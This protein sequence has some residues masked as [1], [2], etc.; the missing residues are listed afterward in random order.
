MS[1]NEI[2]YERHA[3]EDVVPLKVP[4]IVAIDISGA[5]NFRCCFCPNNNE[6][7]MKAERHIFMPLEMFKKI[8]DD[9]AYMENE[10]DGEKVK[11]IYITG[12]GEPMLNKDM[13][14]MIRYCK[15]RNVCREI[16]AITNGSILSPICNQ[17][18][19]ES[20]LD[21]LRISIEALSDE[22]Y[23]NV[24]DVD[25]SFKDLV[26]NIT[27]LYRRSYGGGVKGIS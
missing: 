7:Y 2:R 5:C 18:L 22:G 20:G 6:T 12:T 14:E 17:K 24:C 13:V 21:M 27:D 3:L 1:K 16:R 10:N 8:I 23:R 11:V 25:L 15:S 19:A 26:E 9:I 4:Y